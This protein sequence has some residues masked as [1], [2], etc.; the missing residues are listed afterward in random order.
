MTTNLSN[1][2]MLSENISRSICAE[3]PKGKGAMEVPA[4][5][6]SPAFDLGKGWKVRPCIQIGSGETYEIAHIEGPAIIKSIWMTCFPEASRWLLL[7]I[8]WD[9]EEAPSVEV[10][11]RVEYA[12]LCGFSAYQ[13]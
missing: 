4:D 3:N 9:G 11:Q 8:Y 5:E 2:F 13:C 12:D 6:T 7:R 10:L 1:L